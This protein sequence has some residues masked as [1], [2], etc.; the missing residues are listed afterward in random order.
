MRSL[1]LGRDGLNSDPA[2]KDFQNFS[3]NDLLE[4]VA[5]ATPARIFQV[6]E[7]LYRGVTPEKINEVT[8]I[9]LWFLDQLDVIIGERR[10]LEDKTLKTISRNDLR[11][12]KRLGFS[13]KQLAY[14][15]DVDSNQVRLERIRQG[16]VPVFKTVDTC[17]AE[18]EAN[19]PYHYS[20]YE[21]T[22]EVAAST[23]PKVIILGSGP[24]RIGQGIEFDYCCVHAS[25]ALSEIGYETI[26]INCNPETVSTDYDTSDRLFFEPLT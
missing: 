9:D 20:T 10:S 8:A 17:S 14:L 25:F 18:F 19:T 4:K 21:D 26:M 1:E 12:A 16:V 5:I 22:S 13:D 15:W 2:E 3:E 7:L 11:R 24:N 23:K 6:A